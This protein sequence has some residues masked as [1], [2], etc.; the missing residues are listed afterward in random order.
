MRMRQAAG[1][2]RHIGTLVVLT[3]LA[4]GQPALALPPADHAFGCNSC[5]ILSAE[6][7]AERRGGFEFAGLSFDFGASIRSFIDNR[8]VL[9][10]IVTIT[11]DGIIEH[12]A[13]LPDRLPQADAVG[14]EGLPPA[15]PQPES[16]STT[17]SRAAAADVPAIVDLAGLG[18]ALGV[19]V[20]DRKGFTAALHEATRQRITST[21]INTASDRKLRQEMEIMV[22]VEHFRQFQETTR[23][24]LLNN[25]I[26]ASRLR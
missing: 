13:T 25:R 5:P 26:G 7:L 10:S 12:R 24:S 15:A 14:T 21:L 6:E 20:N 2:Y 9:E 19:S 4:A 23:Q 11:R 8:L 3:G 17:Q 1:G 18:N 22:N 16:A